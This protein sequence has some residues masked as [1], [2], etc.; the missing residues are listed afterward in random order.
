M[1]CKFCGK[2]AGFLRNKH[3]ACQIKDKA[4]QQQ[5]QQ[6]KK[7]IFTK[8]VN[9]G[10][11]ASNLPELKKDIAAIAKLNAI[12]DA[13]VAS[14]I[15]SGWEQSVA[16][17]FEDGILTEA[18]QDNLYNLMTDFGLSQTQLDNN[19]AFTKMVKGAV[20]REVMNGTLPESM[21]V[22]GHLPF[23]LQKTEKIIWVFQNVDY[24][25]QK[26]KTRYV[27]G[28]QGISVRVARG[29][30][31]RTGTF[32]GER[33]QTDETIHADT[34]LMGITNKHIY[35]AGANKRFRINYNKIVAFEPFENG[36]GVQRDAQTAKPQTFVTEDGWF[37][38]NLIVNLAQI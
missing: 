34:G 25:E 9:A 5:R 35:F 23:N 21:K 4:R 20:L 19:G 15:A 36:I 12:D 14:I 7:A 32:K 2:P 26:T 17:A 38:Y 18:E 31:Y 11:V 27:G 22:D 30:Y 10:V 3:K 6:A 33:V 29:L 8:I 24:Y 13:A 37:T 28:S 16:T 1:D